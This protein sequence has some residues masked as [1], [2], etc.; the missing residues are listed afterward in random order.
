MRVLHQNRTVESKV[1]QT[2]GGVKLTTFIPVRFV[3]H[4][5]K[6]VVIEPTTP[7]RLATPLH[8][9][10]APTV[11]DNLMKALGRGFYWQ[12]LLDDG[13]VESI[14]ALAAAEGGDRVR[15]YKVLRLARLAPEI[16]ED[17]ARCRQPAGLSL[18]F[19]MRNPLPDDWDEQRRVIAGLADRP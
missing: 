6:K 18:E 17:I 3:R 10:Q 16:V 11:D 8:P 15:V 5:A 19:F 7:G 4:K 9:G 14:S 12:Q 13:K 2:E 1:Q